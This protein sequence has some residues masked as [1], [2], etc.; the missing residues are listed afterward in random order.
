MKPRPLYRALF[1]TAF[2]W[3][4]GWTD[5]EWNAAGAACLLLIVC[6][7]LNI[8]SVAALLHP[9]RGEIVR[10]YELGSRYPVVY[11]ACVMAYF[12]YFIGNIR[13]WVDP[14]D[15]EARPGRGMNIAAAAYIVLTI[16]ST[17]AAILV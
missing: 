14:N 4:R 10:I 12:W 5:N 3:F 7:F 1:I 8:V 2:W 6:H 13:K 16:L 15:P 17:L 9:G 11:V